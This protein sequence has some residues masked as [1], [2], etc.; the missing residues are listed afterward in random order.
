MKL[1]ASAAL[2]VLSPL[3][4]DAM[5]VSDA[6]TA[7]DDRYLPEPIRW[8]IDPV[9]SELTFRVRHLVSWTPGTF[10]QW[11]GTIIADPDNLASGSVQV[12]IQTASLTTHHERRDNHLRSDDFFDAA[13]HPVITFRST[14]VEATADRLRVHGD[15][16][17]RGTTRP[18]V[19]DGEMVQVS[20]PVG[21][22]RIGF[23]AETRVNRHDFGV[24]WNRAAE[25]GG[26]VLGDEVR[27]R[28]SI[29]AREA[30][31]G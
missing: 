23:E 9:H 8:E 11:G 5:P 19:L 1:A 29:S 6:H 15:L 25:G 17:I 2:L 20:G 18:V 13:N 22:R 16:T 10:T 3:F 14:R 30:P 28:M 27:I 4:L 26:L 24:S 7:P 31:S 21:Q 12:D